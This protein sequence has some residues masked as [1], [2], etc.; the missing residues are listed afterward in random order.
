M[1]VQVW[2]FVTLTLTALLMGTSFA[3]TLEMPVKMNV[4][5]Q[6]W[7]TFQQTLYPYFA[8][9]GGPVEIGA[10]IAAAVLSYLVRAHRPAFFLALGATVCLA[11][12]FFGIWL[13]VTNTVN[14]ETAK[15]TATTSIPPDWAQWRSQWEYSH[16][17]RF[18]LH[19]ISFSA[20][21]ISLLSLSQVARHGPE[22]DL[23]YRID[24]H[25]GR[26]KRGKDS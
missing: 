2:Y 19:L 4:D 10:I 12:A 13:G 20:L 1:F 17:I 9:I 6:L 18:A 25:A 24:K 7:R 22:R 21:L 8:Y 23:R 11:V 3:H 15:W 26:R 14:A 16:L 5:A